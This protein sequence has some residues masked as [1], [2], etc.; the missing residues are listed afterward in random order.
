M[1][2]DSEM[3]EKIMAAKDPVQQKKFGRSVKNYN[4]AKWNEVCE[5]VV[6]KANKE[7]VCLILF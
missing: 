4:D 7:K 1:F 2:E 5:D 6:R 3:A